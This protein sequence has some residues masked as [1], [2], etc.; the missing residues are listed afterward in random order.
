[1]LERLAANARELGVPLREVDRDTFASLQLPDAQRAAARC[2]PFLYRSEAE[3]PTADKGRVPCLIVV[4]DQIEDPHNAGAIIRTAEAVGCAGICLPRRRAVSVTPAVVRASAGATEHL[5][6]FRIGNVARTVE[7]LQQ[8]GYWAVALDHGAEQSWDEADYR[9][10]IALVVGSEGRG[11]RRLVADR[12]D[13]RVA[14]P[15][16]GRVGSLNV[17]AAF[18]AAAYEVVRQQQIATGVAGPE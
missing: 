14:L 2:G 7:R 1:A 3:L 9:G 10:C 6:V 8:A 15:M 5:P 13:H 4:L 11:V 17:S 12:C 16:F 18:A